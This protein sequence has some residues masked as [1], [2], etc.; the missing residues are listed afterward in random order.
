MATEKKLLDLRGPQSRIGRLISFYFEAYIHMLFYRI[1]VP[2]AIL[3]GLFIL[4]Y[5]LFPGLGMGL[6]IYTIVMWVLWTP[7]FLEVAK[8]L[9]LAWSRGMAFGRLNPEFAALYKKRYAKHPGIFIAFPYI[10]A[11]VWTAAFIVMIV[12][13]W[14]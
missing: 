1:V 3:Y 11:V 14:P 2:L 6:K 12:R 5:A 9:S 4:A 10:A 8:G 7:Q 13:W